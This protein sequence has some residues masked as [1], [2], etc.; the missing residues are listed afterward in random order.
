MVYTLK[1]YRLDRRCKSGE[2]FVKMYEYDRRDNAQMEREVNE[3]HLN[4]GY[5]RSQYRIEFAPKFI[6]VKNMMSGKDVQIAADTPWNC[7]PDSESYWSA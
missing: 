2:R 1:I 6:T 5:P 3:L 4:C 7:R